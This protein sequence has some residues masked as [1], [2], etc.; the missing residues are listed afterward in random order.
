MFQANRSAAISHR[1]LDVRETC[2]HTSLHLVEAVFPPGGDTDTG[3]EF[4]TPGEVLNAFPR[5][6]IWPPVCGERF[7]HDG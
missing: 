6:L 5:F 1:W 7:I 3:R 4:G 2:Q